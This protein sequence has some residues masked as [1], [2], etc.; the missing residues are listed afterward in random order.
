VCT[1]P[2]AVRPE[3]AHSVVRD[4]E[5]AAAAGL[6]APGDPVRDA[7]F[8]TQLVMTTFHHDA[9]ASIAPPADLADR[10]WELCYRALGG[11]VERADAPFPSL[12]V[13]AG[14]AAAT[15]GATGIVRGGP[16]APRT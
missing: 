8:V 7:W 2:R 12:D 5:A 3:V 13:R 1:F 4:L 16:R 9:F 10:L 11:P 14:L 15:R 6:L